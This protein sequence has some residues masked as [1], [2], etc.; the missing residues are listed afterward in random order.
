M[1]FVFGNFVLD[2]TRGALRGPEGD[3]PL[4]PRA[5]ALLS[6][7]VENHGRLIDRDELIASVW[8]GRIVSDAAISTAVKTVRKALGDDGD[9][10]VWLQTVRGRGF[11][12][13]G[14]VRL[15]QAAGAAVAEA[16]S[17]VD[18][19]KDS[20]PA[21]AVL[22]FGVVGAEDRL[23]AIGD[24]IPS[25]LIASLSRLRWL[26]VIARGSS[27]RFR[28]ATLDFEALRGLL[29]VGYCLSGNVELFGGDL[30]VSVDLADTRTGA[31][32]WADRLA[33]KAD[34]IAELR[35]R[36]VADVVAALDLH[37]PQ[38]EA[39]RARLVSTE[40]LDAWGLYHLGVSHMMRMNAHDN[41]VAED[42]LGRAIA[43][44]SGFASAHAA[45]SFAK[46]QNVFQRLKTDREAQL[47][48]VRRFAE[49]AFELDPTD[50]QSNYAMGR[51]SWIEGRPEAGLPWMDS[52]LT[53]DPNYA[54]GFYV[55]G[56]LNAMI[57]RPQE[58][59]A[60]LDTA[61]S[62]SP[63]DPL[64][65]A[66]LTMQSLA[67]LETGDLDVAVALGERGAMTPRAHHIAMYA[68]ILSNALA[69]NPD[70]A[71]HWVR[72]VLARRPDANAHDFLT[73]VPFK[74]E[75]FRLNILKALLDAGLPPGK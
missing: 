66:M 29:G 62:L 67:K 23:Q 58:G 60:D 5:F 13:D 46:F 63:L 21:L 30:A 40:N 55:R 7:M 11:R 35:P 32:I 6:L 20:R 28:G 2:S 8:D 15:V 45:M 49:R 65:A 17:A 12:F 22:P 59:S 24:A 33:G 64:L 37:I 1:N 3:I 69:G 39:E 14:I 56:G 25:E 53:L 70:R 75:T 57:Q 50:P 27:F 61:L 10:P 74:D 18:A 34:D 41:R 4:E 31:V 72:F 19:P 54:R 52:A 9:A 42:L 51:V 47:V 44:D 73:A 16:S 36:I 48:E 26:K 43:Q 68:A 38:H 71:R